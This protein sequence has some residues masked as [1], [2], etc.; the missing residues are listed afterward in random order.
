VALVRELFTYEPTSGELRRRVDRWAGSHRRILAA[1]AGDRAGWANSAGYLQVNVAGRLY[2]V[3]RIAFLI[4]EG[5]WPNDQIDHLDGDRTNNAWANLREVDRQTNS[6]NRRR[7]QRN[8][9][10]GLLGVYPHRKRW[11]AQICV[12]GKQC[13]LGDFDTAEGAHAAYLAA[14]REYHAGCTI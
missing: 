13:Y 4:I 11:R 2:L 14:K 7:A 9:Q 5:R 3:H 10:S 12:N 1:R 6:E 8:N